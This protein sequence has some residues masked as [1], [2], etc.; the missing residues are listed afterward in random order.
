MKSGEEQYSKEIITLVRFV[1]KRNG[2]KE[3]HHINRFVSFP[4][5]RFD[6]NNGITVC[7][8]KC[9]YYLDNLSKETEQR[10]A[11]LEIC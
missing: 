9:H 3:V 1:Q 2:D 4:L 7:K 5:E 10:T 6:L 8:G 11:T